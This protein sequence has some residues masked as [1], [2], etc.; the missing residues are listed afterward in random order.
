MTRAATTANSSL[1]GMC[2]SSSNDHPD[3]SASATSELEEISAAYRARKPSY[4]IA[5]QRETPQRGR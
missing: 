5:R 4:T 1:L 3:E 2:S